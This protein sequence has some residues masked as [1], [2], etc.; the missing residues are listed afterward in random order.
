MLFVEADMGFA[1]VHDKL[2]EAE[3]LLYS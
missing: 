1:I 3:Q 2:V